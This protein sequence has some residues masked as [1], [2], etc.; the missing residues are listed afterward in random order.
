MQLVRGVRRQNPPEVTL[1][2]YS[3]KISGRIIQELNGISTLARLG[4]VTLRAL[5]T[6]S[7]SDGEGYRAGYKT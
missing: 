6:A 4:R 7:E 2:N 5:D 1:D 3:P